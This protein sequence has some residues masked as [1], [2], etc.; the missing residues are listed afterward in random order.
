MI[1]NKLDFFEFN[2]F[3]KNPNDNKKEKNKKLTYDRIGD[4]REKSETIGKA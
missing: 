3:I 4:K 2:E 1:Y